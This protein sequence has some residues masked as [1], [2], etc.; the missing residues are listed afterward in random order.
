[1][2]RIYLDHAA[3]TPVL[4]EVV[5]HMHQMLAEQ[6][7]NPSS[8]H[9]EGRKSRAIIEAARRTVA[10]Y[11]N[12]SLGEIFFTSGGTESNNMAL[13]CAVRDMGVTRIISSKIEHHCITHVLE[14]LPVTV[15]W[16]RLHKDGSADLDHLRELLQVDHNGRSM[17]SL[18]HVNNELGTVND[19][20]RIAS[21]CNESGAFFHTDSVQG[22]GYFS[23]DVSR[24][25]IQF[26]SGAAHKFN[27][28]KG[29]GF[30]YINSDH[31]IQPMIYG[32]SQERNMRAGTENLYG[33]SGM[34]LALERAIEERV[35]RRDK[36]TALNK[37]MRQELK[38]AVPDCR[39]N[40]GDPEVH[41]PK[42][43]SVSFPR[44]E[45]ADLLVFNLDI[46]GVAA[47]GGSACS[48]GVES[49]SHVLQELGLAEGYR[50]VR[51]SFSH[52]NTED[53]IRKVIGIIR[54]HI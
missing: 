3:T 47:S 19:I 23:Y 38:V 27:G 26:M 4:P 21:I 40:S 25:P 51:F 11:L 39:I 54:E 22:I 44:T 14:H 16:V 33:I 30:I 2:S 42:V 52:E 1:M 10:K 45:R 31:L 46:A 5:E 15:E 49:E 7:G 32:G 17:V 8:I 41:H 9:A 29:V 13:Q 34:A 43:L 50:T 35:S 24:T 48:S 6:Y 36:L 20:D 53:E 12:S 18:M 37:F 28:P